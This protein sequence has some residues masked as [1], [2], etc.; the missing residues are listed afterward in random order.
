MEET[1]NQ[2][3]NPVRDK[4]FAFALRIIKLYKYLST[5][6]QEYVMSKYMLTTGTNVGAYVESAQQSP[7]RFDFQREMGAALQNA[8]RTEYWLKLLHQSDYLTQQEFDSIFDDAD[9]LVSLLTAIVKSSK[10]TP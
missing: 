9:E 5:D 8:A 10:R 2:K 7:D 4:S 1:K 6:K 3:P